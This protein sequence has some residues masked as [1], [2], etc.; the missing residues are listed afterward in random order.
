MYVKIHACDNSIMANE[1]PLK[2]MLLERQSGLL[3]ILVILSEHGEINY[4]QFIDV[5]K[6]YPNSFYL[7]IKKLIDLGLV[8]TR[9]DNS[10]Y[11]SKKMASLTDKGKKIADH[12]KAINDLL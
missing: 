8:S 7:A 2:I 3:R 10:S 12:L 4:Q 9:I 5:Y 1:R 11:P 6:L